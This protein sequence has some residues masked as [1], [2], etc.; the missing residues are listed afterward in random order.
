M[1]G[2]T[3]QVMSPRVAIGLV[4]VSMLSLIAYFALSAYAPD[5]R[6]DSDGAAHALSKSA[7]GFAGVRVLLDASGL[8]NRVDRGLPSAQKPALTILAPSPDSRGKE[9]AD[10]AFR[11]PSL[12]IL[13]K[14]LP[15]PDPAALGHVLKGSMWGT[16]VVR[17]PLT[18]FSKGTKIARRLNTA[19]PVLA[20]AAGKD[21]A[22]PAGLAAIDSLQ[23]LSGVGWEPIVTTKDGRIVLAKLYNADVYVLSDPDLMNTHGIHDL[24][25]AAF[26]LAVI[27]SIR[28]GDGPVVF[29]VTLNGLRREP[30][31][32]RAI[33]APPFLGATLCAILVAVLIGFHAAVRFGS[34]PAPPPVYARG[35]QALAANAADM[36][37]LLHREP[38]MATRYALTTRNLVL[39]AFGLR[40]QSA[41]QDSDDPLR[42][43][44]REGQLGYG[45][46]LAEA[47]RVEN[48]T[49]LVA[50]ARRLSQ[51]RE[52]MLH[53]R[54]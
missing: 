6:D 27:R 22:V 29:D 47:H 10:L 30:S 33:F 11:N 37:R 3:T 41:L 7:I 49:D 17:E 9:V 40:R 34:P 46:L 52:E 14:W 20:A 23:T 26:A 24:P 5:F 1:S 38:H 50:L 43:R 28:K 32:L 2:E 31:L 12:I 45:D 44:E 13:P 21:I 42:T 19:V 16:A 15:F 54:Q 36:I 35:K 4:L 51:W 8:P 53:A 39:R 18:L 25:T 48:R